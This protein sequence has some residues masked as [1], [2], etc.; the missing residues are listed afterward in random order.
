MVSNEINGLGG[1]DGP[2]GGPDSQGR[3]KGGLGDQDESE[4][5]LGGQ[6]NVLREFKRTQRSPNEAQRRVRVNIGVQGTKYKRMVLV[7]VVLVV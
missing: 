2:E 6:E 4:G 7:T 5:G 1:Q 3:V